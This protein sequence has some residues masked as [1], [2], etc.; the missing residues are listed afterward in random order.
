MRRRQLRAAGLA[1][2]SLLSLSLLLSCV[3]YRERRLREF[4]SAPLMGVVFDGEQKP[5]VGALIAVDGRAGPRTDIN[6]RF[7]IDSLTRGDHRIGVEKPG[8]EPLEVS[9][10]FLDRT[11]VLYLSVVSLGQL[12]R[13]AE[14][15]LDRQKLGDADGLLRRAEAL[16]PE[17][18]VGL[19]LRAV[20]FTKASQPEKAVAVLEKIL[21]QNPR[22]PA[23]LLTLADIYQ[24]QLKDLPKAVSLLREYLALDNNPGIR[25][26]LGELKAGGGRNP[27]APSP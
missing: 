13:Q 23:V 15:A 12:L 20:Y 8:Y 6:G 26:R 21:G 24:Y 9:I 22:L 18:P 2:L 7:L 5:C 1:L 10:H 3:T 27:E 11:Q 19:Y 14:E 25:S 16:N 4:R 17:D